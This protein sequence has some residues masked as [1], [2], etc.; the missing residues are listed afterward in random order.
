MR[1]AGLLLIGLLLATN[2]AAEDELRWSRLNVVTH[3]GNDGSVEVSETHEFTV[4]GSY[5]YILRSMNFG[6]DQ[7]AS[8]HGVFRLAADGSRIPLKDTT[9]KCADCYSTYFWGLQIYLRGESDPPF[10]DRTPRKLVIE[11]QLVSG[12]TPAWDLAGGPRPLESETMFRNPLTRASEVIAAWKDASP[13]LARNYRLDHDV[14]FPSIGTAG[15]I[16]ELNYRLEYD[17]SWVLLDKERPTGVATPEVDYRVTHVLQYLPAGRPAAVNVQNALLRVGAVIA[18]LLLGLGLLLFF[19]LSNRVFVR[20]PHPD[21]ALFE[22]RIAS[23]PSELV[24]AE[25]G[26][27]SG[28]PPLADFL[29]R[30]AAEKKLSI[31]VDQAETDD[32]N[33]K[34]SM[35]LTTTRDK[36]RPIER[37]LIAK[38][39]GSS[40]TISSETIQDRYRGKSFNPQATLDEAFQEAMPA[41]VAKRRPLWAALHLAMMAAGIAAMVKSLTEQ[42]LSDPFPLF[43][44][45][46]PGYLILQV[47]PMGSSTHRRGTWAL[48]LPVVVLGVLGAAIALSP[49]KPLSGFASL[50]LALLGAG[51]CAGL[52]ARVPRST[53]ADLEFG[54]ARQFVLSELRKPRPDLRDAWVESIDAMGE[55]RAVKRWKARYAGQFTGAPDLSEMSTG[56]T[57]SGPPFTGEPLARPKLPPDWAEGFSVYSDDEDE[58]E[59]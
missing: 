7:A 43:A 8:V 35:R 49:N 24:A 51:H 37:E 30:M 45:L 19:V 58:D 42:T 36:L 2:A 53:E 11:Y 27:S 1:R 5:D 39:F 40:D 46:L 10:P 32:D 20:G 25:S 33:A 3:L 26:W 21:R 31:T 23:V 50:G 9:D 12:L 41:R 18:P 34:M 48:L 4:G 29:G 56:P 55:S 44:S 57:P 13:G 38:I 52:L 16:G 6:P 28:A 14:V 47:W 59:D 54:A 22:R 15:P 17:D